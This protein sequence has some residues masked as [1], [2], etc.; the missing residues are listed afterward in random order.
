M[1]YVMF[2]VRHSGVFRFFPIIFGENEVH[3]Q[4]AECIS[5]IKMGPKDRWA[6][7]EPVSAGTCFL[8][9]LM[10]WTCV[11]RSESLGLAAHPEDAQI[12]NSLNYNMGIGFSPRDPV[13]P[14]R[15]HREGTVRSS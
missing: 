10:G 14:V 1:K 3:A 8:D 13:I 12:I 6:N 4:I 15:R 2:R 7:P 9:Q 11:G 5:Q